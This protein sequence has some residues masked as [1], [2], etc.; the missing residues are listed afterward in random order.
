MPS[1]AALLIEWIER[2]GYKQNELPA[3]LGLHESF[4][5]MLVNGKRIPSLHNAVKIEELTGIPVKSWT[6]S[7]RDKS[8]R[9]RRPRP[10]KPISLQT[11]N[12]DVR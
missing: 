5:S 11:V 6:S 9:T 7:A 1:G 8:K 3:I 4:I 10:R 12:A 2:R